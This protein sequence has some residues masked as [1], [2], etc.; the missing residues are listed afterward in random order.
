MQRIS[1]DEV[2]AKACHVYALRHKV[3]RIPQFAEIPATDA[4]R[5]IG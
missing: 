1:T 3:E 5:I 2:F 4:A